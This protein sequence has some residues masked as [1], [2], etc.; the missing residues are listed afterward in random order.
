VRRYGVKSL[1][2]IPS[3]K[4]KSFDDPGVRALW[5]VVVEEG[6][7]IDL[8]LMRFAMVESAAKMLAEFPQLTFGF[9][10]C[11]DLKPGPNLPRD[12]KAVLDLARFKNLYAKADFVGTGTQR[13]YP[14]KTCTTPRCRLSAPVELNGAYGQA[15]TRTK[16]GPPRSPTNS[17]CA[18]SRRRSRSRIA[19]ES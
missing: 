6:T 8:F 18:S 1:R 14:A 17:T 15:A 4:A 7:T 3:N 2:S 12:L 11:M 19:S 9:C 10:H 13:P 5:K 16:S